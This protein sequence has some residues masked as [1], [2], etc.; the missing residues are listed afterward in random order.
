MMCFQVFLYTTHV[1]KDKQYHTL[2]SK[3]KD[4]VPALTEETVSE[5]AVFGLVGTFADTTIRG[6]RPPKWLVEAP[7]ET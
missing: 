6:A 7:P 5:G 3:K 1:H 4:L 2:T